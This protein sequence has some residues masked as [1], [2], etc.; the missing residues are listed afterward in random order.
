MLAAGWL[1]SFADI[2]QW[3]SSSQTLTLIST[4]LFPHFLFFLDVSFGIFLGVIL[5]EYNVQSR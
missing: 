1:Y 3:N 5:V 2:L 4:S